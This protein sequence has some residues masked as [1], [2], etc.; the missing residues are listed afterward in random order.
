MRKTLVLAVA[1]A[2]IVAAGCEKK[3]KKVTVTVP[4]EKLA[5]SVNDWQLTRE[6]VETV[7]RR[8]PDAERTKYSTPEGMAK[9]TQRLM[10]EQMAYQEALKLKLE[11][12]ED[13]AK[14]I[15]QATRDILV[16]KYIEEYVDSKARPSD[17]E[18]HEYYES[19]QDRYTKLAQIRAQHIFSKDK[20]K[21]EDIKS[22]IVDGGEKFTTLAQTYSEDGLTKASGGDLGFFN[23]GG[24]I[25][26]VGFSQTFSDQVAVMEPGKIYG[27]IKWEQGYSLVRVNEKTPAQVVPYEDVRDDIAKTL[28]ATKLDEVRDAQ[29]AEV[30]K[31]YK[32][33]NYLQES[34]DKT[35]RGPQE[36]FDYAQNSSDPQ[37]R[38]DAFQKIVDKYPEDKVAPQAM[39][40]IGFVYAE[41]LKDAAMADKTFTALIEKYPDNEMAQTA[42]WML[43]NLD[44]PL[45]K[46]QDLDDLNHQIEQKK[47][48]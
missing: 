36:L 12:R 33:H 37:Q 48:K 4:V 15:E 30:E 26:S 1:L 25:K 32:T 9:L 35:Q 43:D 19:H 29:F 7:L 47:S 8:M 14:Q 23:P 2:L 3:A 45:P 28:A 18:M 5:G 22:R 41:E 40:M 27:P 11:K 21:L 42:R 24:Y 38:I 16:S 10:Q 44:K 46:F 34:F 13:I 20:A 17:E 6:Q 31:N 39:F